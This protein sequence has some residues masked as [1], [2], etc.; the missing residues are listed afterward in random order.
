MI[1]NALNY[2]MFYKT[3]PVNSIK[4]AAPGLCFCQIFLSIA[5]DSLSILFGS[6]FTGGNTQIFGMGAD[7]IPE[8]NILSRVAKESTYALL[9]LA[10]DAHINVI[11]VLGGGY[12]PDDF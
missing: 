9:K 7:Y 2:S 11:R 3:K 1:N 4:I 8:D 12:Y 6:I 5:S 10:K